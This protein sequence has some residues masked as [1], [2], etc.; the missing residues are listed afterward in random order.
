MLAKS[1][2]P[3]WLI[4]FLVATFL[5]RIPSLF[6]PYWYGD[7]GI[8][9]TLGQGI[10]HGLTLYRDI[11]DN[12]PP[13]LYLTAAV[14]GN[15]FWL[16]AIL[17]FWNLATIILFWKLIS[18]LFE[19]EKIARIATITFGLLITPPLL[20]GNIV[21]G[22]IFMILPTLGAYLLLFAK[23]Q[24][25]KNIYFAGIILG[26]G[27]LF[28]LPSLI[29]IAAPVGLWLALSFARKTTF[30]K[31]LSQSIIFFTGAITPIAATIVFYALSGLAAQYIKYAL[32]ANI[33][34]LSTWSGT[35]GSFLVRNQDLIIRA[36]LTFFGFLILN[37]LYQKEKITKSFFFVS[38]WFAASLFAATLSGR[39]Y[40]HYLLQVVPSLSVILALAISARGHEQF[41]AYPMFLI[42]GAV[43]VIFKFYYYPVF[44]YYENFIK[45]ALRQES[46]TQYLT[47]F[48]ARTPRNY[49][50]AQFLSESYQK[51]DKLFIWGD[52]PEL[53][54]LSKITPATP[55]VAAYHVAYYSQFDEV[56]KSLEA[57]PPR[58]IV[59]T[60][61]TN[62]F[63]Q[64]ETI[65]SKNYIKGK[66]TDGARVY[67]QIV[68]Q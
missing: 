66:Q 16:K 63:P 24:S 9:L 7:E 5:L 54:A 26:V 43:L 56:A 45:F 41:W 51:G 37:G 21:N 64:L 11:I 46:K 60:G 59:V 31:F 28:K 58:F 33:G 20:E 62:D 2:L 50:I 36:G 1:Y 53:Y 29:D 48:D 55:Y 25:Y 30:G 27:T 17:A 12:K 15:L 19:K 61:S 35:G 3:L 39:P 49:E 34:Y 57:S 65:L 32:L 47:N 52:D 44:S 8:T 18:T 23:K 13:L 38:L 14:A 40:P 22:E 10:S 42:L 68:N 67:L 6:E 4:S